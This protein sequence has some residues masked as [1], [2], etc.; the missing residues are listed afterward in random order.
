MAYNSIQFSSINNYFV[1]YTYLC[2][3]VHF[4]SQSVITLNCNNFI[5][6]LIFYLK[7]KRNLYLFFCSNKQT[8]FKLLDKVFKMGLE[9]NVKTA[10][11]SYFLKQKNRRDNYK[12]LSLKTVLLG[13]LWNC[14]DINLK[15]NSI[16]LF[17][18]NRLNE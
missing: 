12:N 8:I 18:P 9:I 7:K 13:K 5:L 1:W 16:V 15:E 4:S 3:K 2:R 6:F 14:R 11:S 10:K 17:K